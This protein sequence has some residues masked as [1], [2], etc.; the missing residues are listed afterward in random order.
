MR[1]LQYKSTFRLFVGPKTENLIYGVG[2]HMISAPSRYIYNIIGS[3]RSLPYVAYCRGR[4]GFSVKG[5]GGG[6][7]GC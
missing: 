4:S 5:G 6:V 7:G 1:Q 2:L 3:L